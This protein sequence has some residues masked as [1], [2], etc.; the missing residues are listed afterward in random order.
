MKTWT[1]S[2]LTTLTLTSAFISSPAMAKGKHKGSSKQ[3]SDVVAVEETKSVAAVDA[4]EVQAP[5]QA[6]M[7][8]ETPEALAS[9]ANALPAPPSMQELLAQGG[10]PE[11]KASMQ[12]NASNTSGSKSSAGGSSLALGFGLF[13]MGGGLGAGVV[14]GRRKGSKASASTQTPRLKHVKSIRLSPKHQIS[15]IE[16]QGRQLVVGITSAQ[17]T[18]LATLDDSDQDAAFASAFFQ[19]NS[20]TPENADKSEASKAALSSSGWDELFSSAIKQRQQKLHS[21]VPHP[22]SKATHKNKPAEPE[23][24]SV[25]V[26]LPPALTSAPA[27]ERE[28]ATQ[29]E[30]V[31][32]EPSLTS[33]SV[34]HETEDYTL[35]ENEED[36]SGQDHPVVRPEEIE[37]LARHDGMF[38]EHDAIHH[39]AVEPRRVR[40]SRES[41]SM[42]IALAAMREEVSR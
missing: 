1:L 27:E 6:A 2:L 16:T 30:P 20:E 9:G 5:E 17:M 26:D 10:G 37:K 32:M 28:L 34:V 21:Q 18:L 19:G 39:P 15:L 4:P 29:S 11:S 8:E 36:V 23:S 31:A 41:D 35:E 25:I 40:R 12:G 22:E 13:L 14:M 38:A 33:H 7:P 24:K 42:L 3:A